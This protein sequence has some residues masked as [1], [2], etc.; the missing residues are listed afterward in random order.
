VNCG[1]SLERRIGV[2]M[3][4]DKASRKIWLLNFIYLMKENFFERWIVMQLINE[5]ISS[6]LA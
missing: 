3:T 2:K 1:L 6:L 4:E 5:K